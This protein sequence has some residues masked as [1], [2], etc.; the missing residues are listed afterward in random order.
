MSELFRRFA[1]G[2][3]PY[4]LTVDLTRNRVGDDEGFSASFTLDTYI[5]LIDGEEADALE[6]S[7]VIAC[8]VEAGG[9]IVA[10]AAVR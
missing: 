4:R 10:L 7:D 6:L 5:H 3:G 1:A 8:P 9:E 2:P